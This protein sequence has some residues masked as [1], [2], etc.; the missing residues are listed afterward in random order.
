MPTQTL[1]HT[2]TLRASIDKT[3]LAE[4]TIMGVAAQYGVPIERGF[5]IFEQIQAGAFKAQVG[6]P[7][8]VMVLWQHDR[9]NPIGRA[10]S[11]DDGTSEL[12]FTA[13]ISEHADVPEARKALAL[14]REGI[15]DEVSVGFD[16]GTWTEKREGDKMTIMHT[17]ARLREFS[18]VTFGALGRGARVVTVANEQLKSEALAY[19][20]R[21][22]RLNS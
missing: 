17:K 20:A 1:E 6:A 22:A 15:V 14:L 5:N 8:R 11:L 12:R 16:W 19:R 10:L 13:K 4:G 7:N 9:D 21:L 18:V 3:N 2:T